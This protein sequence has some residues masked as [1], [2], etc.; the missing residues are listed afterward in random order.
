MISLSGNPTIPVFTVKP[1]DQTV[2][3]GENVTFTCKAESNPPSTVVWIK[4][5]EINDAVLLA[6]C[7]TILFLSVEDFFTLNLKVY[8]ASSKTVMSVLQMRG[9]NWDNLQ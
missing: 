6:L 3:K 4:V 9:G 2:I 1:T 5:C 8:L 7:I